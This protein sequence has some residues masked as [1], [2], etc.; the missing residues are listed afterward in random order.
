L[1]G[2][3]RTVFVASR[4]IAP[5]IQAA[6]SRAVAARERRKL[7]SML[8]ETGV[9]SDVE[10]WLAQ[11]AE[12]ALAALRARGEATAAE[13]AAEDPRLRTQIVLARGK[14]YQGRQSVSSRLLF[15]LA[16]EG[17]VVRGRPLGS[18]TSQQYN[19]SPTAAWLPDDPDDLDRWDTEQA[20][21]AL[22]HRWLAA[23]GPATPDDLRWWA[24]WTKTQVKRVL[25]QLPLVE[26]DLDDSPG[27]VLADDLDAPTPCEPWAAMLPALD[28]TPMGW[29][30]RGWF[31]G[32]HGS[33]LFDNTGNIGPSLW[34]NGRIVGGW[35]QS[36]TGDVL[37]RLLED[38]GTEAT[39][40]LDAA[41]ARLTAILGGHRLSARARGKTWLESELAATPPSNPTVSGVS[42]SGHAA[43]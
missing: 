21:V 34:W 8:T 43:G 5:L 17:L 13:L 1:L 4:E 11:T 6:C 22:A 25:G 39:A 27:I 30:Q 19:W 33:K 23:Y 31:L 9:G 20:E 41:A 29:L 42:D 38:V 10:G 40:A 2:M 7:I 24:G 32:E 16:A 12:V 18:W 36:G 14:S 35:A 3:R 15:L 28:P 26:V 37:Y